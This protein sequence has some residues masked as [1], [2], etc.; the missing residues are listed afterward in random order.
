MLFL[1]EHKSYGI[2]CTDISLEQII[3]IYFMVQRETMIRKMD[4]LIGYDDMTVHVC[5]TV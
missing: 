1:G 2:K 5:V 3:I 4:I